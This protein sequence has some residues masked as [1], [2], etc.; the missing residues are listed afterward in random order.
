[1]MASPKAISLHFSLLAARYHR[2]SK[3]I[4]TIRSGQIS[5]DMFSYLPSVTLTEDFRRNIH[6]CG[7][8]SKITFQQ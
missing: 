3:A 8:T 6:P 4:V 7:F 2:G 5:H 1:M